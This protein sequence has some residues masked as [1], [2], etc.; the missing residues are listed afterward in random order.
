MLRKYAHY[1]LELGR[2]I[3]VGATAYD[4]GVPLSLELQDEVQTAIMGM[5]GVCRELALKGPGELLQGR[6]LRLPASG[7]EYDLLAHA[8]TGELKGRLLLYMDPK[9]AEYYRRHHLSQ[10]TRNALPGSSRELRL[11]GDSYACGSPTACVFHCLR[12][13]EFGLGAL[14]VDVGLTWTRE[15]WHTII[16]QIEAAIRGL[17][18]SLPKGHAKEERLNGLAQAAMEFMHFKE[19]WRNY[20][21]H[22][23][24]IYD[25]PDAEDILVHVCTFLE[26][27]SDKLGLKE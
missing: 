2:S 6:E 15:Q 27:L 4:R 21:T 18:Q 10:D 3:E 8:V 12:A 1:Y 14:A 19:G 11:A 9:R 5:Q 23:R 25:D 7:H 26:R 24:I 13:L 17:Q 20:V 16:E 22:N